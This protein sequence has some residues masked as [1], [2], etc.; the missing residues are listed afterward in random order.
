[1]VDV[2]L[3]PENCRIFR[4][5]INLKCT[6]IIYETTS[7]SMRSW[8]KS[9]AFINNDDGIRPRNFPV[10]SSALPKRKLRRGSSTTCDERFY[11]TMPL[12]SPSL[13]SNAD[14]WNVKRGGRNWSRCCS[15]RRHPLSVSRNQTK[16][17]PFPKWRTA[18]SSKWRRLK[19]KWTWR[20]HL[21]HFLAWRELPNVI[22]AVACL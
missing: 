9:Q 10:G 6:S 20:G 4:K 12:F 13:R 8:E 11:F 18:C 15:W 14:K 5:R 16:W 3:I 2:A 1:L 7:L 19:K 17:R 22:V 21:P